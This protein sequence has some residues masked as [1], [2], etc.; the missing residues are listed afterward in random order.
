MTD[1]FR[2]KKPR[3]AVPKVTANLIEG[4]ERAGVVK[5]QIVAIRKTYDIRLMMR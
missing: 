4:L 1:E 3:N 5:L 2:K